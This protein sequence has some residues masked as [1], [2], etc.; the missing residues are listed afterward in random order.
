MGPGRTMEDAE[1]TKVLTASAFSRPFAC[2]AVV[3]PGRPRILLAFR[4]YFL[5]D[6]F[7]N[8]NVVSTECTLSR[9]ST[10]GFVQ[11][12]A[13]QSGGGPLFAVARVERFYRPAR[14]TQENPHET[15]RH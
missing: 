10:V 14:T 5:S 8:F 7:D 12:E 15:I 11:R 13:M 6:L 3:R 1:H 9:N 4:L 2:F